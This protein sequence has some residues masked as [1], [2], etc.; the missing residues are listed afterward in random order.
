MPSA[1]P[2]A[3]DLITAMCQWDPNRRPTAVQCLQH[4]YFQVRPAWGCRATMLWAKLGHA[5]RCL[6]CKRFIFLTGTEQYG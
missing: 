4:P 5:D 1:S 6:H 3:V 2:E